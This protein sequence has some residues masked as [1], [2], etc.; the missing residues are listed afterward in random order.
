MKDTH[1]CKQ[2]EVCLLLYWYYYEWAIW[3]S[4]H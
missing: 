4:I 3:N 1:S 2:T